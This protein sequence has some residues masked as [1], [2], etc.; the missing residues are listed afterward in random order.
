[1]RAMKPLLGV[2]H[3]R[4][5]PSAARHVSMDEVLSWAFADAAALARGGVTGICVENFGDAPFCKGTKD[6]P[7]KPDVVAAI[8]VV[9]REVAERHGLPVMVNCLRNDGVAALGIAAVVGAKWVRVNVL[10]SA[11]VT[12]QGLIEGE[13]ARLFAYRRQLGVRTEVMAD[14][15][16][17]H[18]TPLAPFEQDAAARDLAERSGAS[19]VILSGSRTGEPVDVTLLDTVRKA[20]GAF[21]IWLGSGLSAANAADLWP[22]CDG[23]IVGTA[24]KRGGDVTQRVD[25]SRVKKLVAALRA[26]ERRRAR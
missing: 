11:Y 1:M 18:A 2:V 20:V 19:G 21:P 17:K 22:R 5:L 10:A 12:D 25:P 4:A 13:A 16:V 14:F 15:L 24:L 6:D 3:L 26:A 8:A 9:A 23:A 7:V